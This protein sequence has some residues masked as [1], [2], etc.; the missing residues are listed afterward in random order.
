MR[1]RLVN[2]Q[3]VRKLNQVFIKTVLTLLEA[4]Y[5]FLGH[6]GRVFAMGQKLD[7]FGGGKWVYL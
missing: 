4:Y 7:P 1:K 6:L 5:V 3:R 2:N